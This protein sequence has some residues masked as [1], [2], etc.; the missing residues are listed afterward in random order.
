MVNLFLQEYI[1]FWKEFI[2]PSFYR[3]VASF[4]GALSV[5]ILILLVIGAIGLL[6]EKLGVSERR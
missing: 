5:V 3:E 2:T 1:N 4:A 6:L